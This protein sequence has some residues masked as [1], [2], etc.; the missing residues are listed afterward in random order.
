M[1]NRLCTESGPCLSRDCMNNARRGTPAYRSGETPDS[2]AFVC[3]TCYGFVCV[4]CQRVPVEDALEFCDA[5]GEAEGREA[6]MEE[7]ERSL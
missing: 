4:G 7:E 2:W 6:R 5:C 3:G 1:A